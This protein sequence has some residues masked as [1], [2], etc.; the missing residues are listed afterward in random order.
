M[1]QL[2]TS[3]FLDNADYVLL[4]ADNYLENASVL[5]QDS[6]ITAVG[7][8]ISPPGNHAVEWIDC[9]GMMLLPG[10]INA[11]NHVVELVIRGLGKDLNTEEWMK[12]YVYPIN[13]GLSDED[14]YAATLLGCADMLRNGSTSVADL[15]P[16]YVRFHA[17]P[18]VQGFQDV[19]FR[20]GVA[21]A[22]ATRS[23][24]DEKEVRA[25][26]E[27]IRRARDFLGRWQGD[28]LV[29]AWIGPSGF[30]ACDPQTL[31]AVKEVASE[32]HT[33]FHIHLNETRFQ[34]NLAQENGYVGQIAWAA[35]SGLLDQDT[36]VAHAVWTSPEEIDLLAETGAQVVHN[37]TSNQIL[38]SGI[39]PVPEMLQAGVVVALG[40]D[41]PG[42][43]DSMDMVAELKAATLLH[44]VHTLNPDVLSARDSLRMLLV[45]G[46][47]ALGY[48]PTELGRIASGALADITAIDLHNNPSINP[49][50]DPVSS[51]V[52]SGSGRDTRLTIVNGK[53][54]FRDG[55][56]PTIGRDRVIAAARQLKRRVAELTREA[57]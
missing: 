30:H 43:N 42:S 12:A 36:L 48:E 50:H 22:A 8:G 32:H 10:L 23:L 18:I 16:N 25:P 4:D 29:R 49:I 34:L 44:R 2:M 9:Q 5:I 19:G 27:E 15:L 38:A 1:E 56:Y 24:I 7:A 33:R 20:A 3:L 14:Y 41:G 51:L 37:A 39:A 31:R 55:D 53:V 13:K 28:G 57:A 40:S 52:F 21:L 35:D 45:G 26:E 17:G 54:L 46:A 6:R 47:Q 11:H